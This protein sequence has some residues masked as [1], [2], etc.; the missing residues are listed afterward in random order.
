MRIP[1]WLQAFFALTA[2]LASEVAVVYTGKM[3]DQKL[4]APD[5]LMYR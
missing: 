5:S 1:R 2:V 3:V 4:L